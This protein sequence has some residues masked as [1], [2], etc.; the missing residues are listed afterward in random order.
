MAA[1]QYDGMLLCVVVLS[2]S[3]AVP[4]PT[5]AC[6]PAPKRSQL[7][8]V[9]APSSWNGIRPITWPLAPELWLSKRWEASTVP[10]SCTL[11]PTC[12]VA[13]TP[14]RATLAWSVRASQRAGKPPPC[15]V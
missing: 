9:E 14:S 4:G 6:T 8:W 11:P 5:G 12:T 13:S 3:E 2:I 1:S 10:S 7:R 15:S